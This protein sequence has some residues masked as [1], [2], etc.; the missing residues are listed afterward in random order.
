MMEANTVIVT[1]NMAT[2]GKPSGYWFIL[3]TEYRQNVILGWCAQFVQKSNS[4]LKI[5][6]ARW[7]T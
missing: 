3:L 1:I 7:V 6:G 5:L 2:L 4:H